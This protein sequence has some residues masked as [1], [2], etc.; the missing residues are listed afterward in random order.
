MKQRGRKSAASLSVVASESIFKRPEPPKKLS[1]AEGE[2]WKAVVATKPADW[3]SNDNLP[4]LA[5][6]C[7]HIIRQD[8]LS[9]M[10]NSHSVYASDPEAIKVYDKLLRL[11]D[12]ETKAI[13]ML[14]T[15]MRL[16]QQSKYG[17]RAAETASRRVVAKKPWEK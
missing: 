16:A 8:K 11:S 9:E 5:D 15:K 10:I 13:A 12:M 2:I 3:F 6:Y 7:R 4:L 14:A 1:D 17:A